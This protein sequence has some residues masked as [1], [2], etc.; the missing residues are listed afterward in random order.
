M[1]SEMYWV[2]RYVDGAI[3]DYILLNN[4]NFFW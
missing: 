2:M 3:V 4:N 1:I